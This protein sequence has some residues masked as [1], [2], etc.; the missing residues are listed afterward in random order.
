MPRTLAEWQAWLYERLQAYEQAGRKALHPT[1]AFIEKWDAAL[2][3]PHR[4]YPILHIAGT[5]GKGSVAALLANI[6]RQAGYKVGFHT[7]PHFFTFTER[8]RVNGAEPPAAWVDAF[9]ERWANFITAENLS[10]FEVT[11][12]LSL[13][14]FAEA[15]VDIAVVEVGLG[16]TWDA[17]N[18][19][20]PL[21][22]VITSIGWDH[23]EVLGHSLEAIAAQKAGII[24]PF[25]PVVLGPE[26]P[27]AALTA[28]RRAAALR[29]APLYI[30][31]Y[32]LLA[33]GW[34]E[35][36]AA[37]YRLFRD[38][39]AGT[40]WECDLTGDYQGYN[41][42]TVLQV[43]EVLRLMGWRISDMALRRGIRQA[44]REAPL[45][46]RGQWVRKKD[47]WIL[48][49]VAHNESAF[50][51]LRQFLSHVP[52]KPQALVLGFSREKAVEAALKAL[53]GWPGEV[54]FTAAQTPRALPPERLRALAEPLGYLG[55][56][57][58]SVEVAVRAALEKYAGIL[59]TGSLFLVA[60]A[61][62]ALRAL[63]E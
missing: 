33:E 52:M 5:N 58:P 35:S 41:L 30:T 40:L 24:K 28:C 7:S 11:V 34:V 10:F 29:Q 53:G 14:W 8:L 42:A 17:T 12:G 37:L 61:L 44:A 54:F 6:L 45:Y 60:E 43:V 23:M 18:I 2:G 46:G 27:P 50:W 47:R 55:A 3:H 25:R 26:L 15:A 4:R 20:S 1:L 9:L 48:L 21:L 22:S 63:P 59:V 19:V 38:P 39:K 62:A 56:V 32:P 49:D 36:G 31:P 16:G 13:A 57:Y 51:A